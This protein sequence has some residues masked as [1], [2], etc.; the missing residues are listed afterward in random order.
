MCMEHTVDVRHC[1]SHFKHF[2]VFGP[3]NASMKYVQLLPHL[4]D[5][6]SEAQR[7]SLT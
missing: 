6:E 7:S 5:V 2:N 1:F 3:Q 4:P